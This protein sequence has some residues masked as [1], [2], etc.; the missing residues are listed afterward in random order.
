MN[1]Q[2]A[3]CAR[4][5]RRPCGPPCAVQAGRYVAPTEGV[6]THEARRRMDDVV[7]TFCCAAGARDI[8]GA[9]AVC[10]LPGAHPRDD[11]LRPAS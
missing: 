1:G 7:Y 9:L 8:D 3:A 11:S 10:R 4:G 5:I 6:D 2:R